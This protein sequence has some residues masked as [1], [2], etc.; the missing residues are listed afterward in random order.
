MTLTRRQWGVGAVAAAGGA[1]LS[2]CSATNDSSSVEPQSA[3]TAGR[4]NTARQSGGSVLERSIVLD[5]HCDTPERI[6]QERIDL[7]QR[8]TDGQLH[9]PRMRE[10]DV[11]GVFFSIYTSAT[12]GTP[13]GAVKKALAIIDAEATASE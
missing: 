5:L 7:S 3:G 12:E 10:G 11:T 1:L 9:I 4:A 6:V 8:D 2:G 13:L